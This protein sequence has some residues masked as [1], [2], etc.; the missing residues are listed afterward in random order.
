MKTFYAFLKDF[1]RMTGGLAILFKDTVFFGVRSPYE[2]RLILQQVHEIGV[3]SLS[4]TNLTLLFTGMVLALQ[5]SYSLSAYGAKIYIGDLVALSVVRELGPV[6]TALM[7][8]ARVGAGITAE[9][10]SMNVTEQIDALRALASSPIKKLVVPRVYAMLFILPLVTIIGIF[11]GIMGGCFIAIYELGQS[12]QYFMQHVIKA[13]TITDI[14]NGIGK[15]FFFA[16][17]I[18]IVACYNGMTAKGGADGVGKATTNTVVM[19]S[20]SIFIA[21]FFLTKLFLLLS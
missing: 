17:I 1:I 15:T 3:R 18:S 19:A 13:L 11:V 12:G 4:I 21:D 14:L 8:G 16:L 20:I 9:I 2:F 6:L 5:T 7:I 10:G